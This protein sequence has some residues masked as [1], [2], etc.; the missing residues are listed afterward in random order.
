MRVVV[1]R[2][3]GQAVVVVRQVGVSKHQQQV[4][5]DIPTA[6]LHLHFAHW[7][8]DQRQVVGGFDVDEHDQGKE[9]AFEVDAINHNVGRAM[10]VLGES[11]GDDPLVTTTP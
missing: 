9:E 3:E 5:R 6:G 4:K 1:A 10:T 11:E 8:R 2:P 7:H